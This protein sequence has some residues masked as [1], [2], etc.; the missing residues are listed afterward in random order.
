MRYLKLCRFP[1]VFTALAD[2][3]AGF[4]LSHPELDPL[5]EFLLLLLASAGLYL[6]GMVLND[7]FDVKQ[8]TEERPHRPLPSGEVSLRGAIVFATGLMAIGL[9]AA[10]LAN[11]KSG[12]VAVAIAVCVLLYDGVL[13]KT[14]LGPVLMGSCRFLNILLGASSSGILINAVWQMPQIWMAA[15]MGIYIVGVTWYARTEAVQS[16]RNQ[17]IGGL[18]LV[19]IGLVMIVLWISG[20]AARFGIFIGLG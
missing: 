14:P 10:F 7:I 6:S 19:N 9:G 16:N 4:L 8:D 2:I 5:P 13:K 11:W 12:L 20:L 17:L 3:F 15:A 1:T 18:A